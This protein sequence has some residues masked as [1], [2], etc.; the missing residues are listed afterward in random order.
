MTP[1]TSMTPEICITAGTCMTQDT[2]MIPEICIAAETCMTAEICITA[3]TFMTAE[4]YTSIL[5]ILNRL[6]IIKFC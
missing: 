6:G 1:E 3:G 2:S 5:S 4:I